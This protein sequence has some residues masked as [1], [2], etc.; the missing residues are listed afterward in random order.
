MNKKNDDKKTDN[1]KGSDHTSQGKAK[2]KPGTTT[3]GGSNYGQGSSQLGNESY[4]QGQKKDD[5]S[6][7]DNEEGFNEQ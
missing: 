7:Y 1:N 6:N 5:G 2:Y 3:Q 4:E